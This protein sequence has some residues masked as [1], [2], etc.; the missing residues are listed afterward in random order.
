VPRVR[1]SKSAIFRVADWKLRVR[2]QIEKVRVV[3]WQQSSE[4]R[5]QIGLRRVAI[6]DYAANL[7]HLVDIAKSRD[8]DVVFLLLSNNEDLG[9]QGDAR[10]MKAWTPYR[11]VMRETAER[12][13]APVI[14]VPALFQASGLSKQD[15]FLDKMH[16]TARGHRII[17][18]ALGALLQ[19][20]G[21]H[22][23]KPL[24]RDGTGKSRPTYEDPFLKGQDDS[25]A[26][27]SLGD[28]PPSEYRIEGVVELSDFPQGGVIHL[29]VV[30]PGRNQSEVLKSIQIQGPGSFVLPVGA[31]RQVVI[32]AYVDPEG[33]GP[34]AD[35]ARYA[36]EDDVIDLSDGPAKGVVIDLNG[37]SLRGG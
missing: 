27:G 1:L 29:D 21:W 26:S 36:F 5:G 35:D 19:E 18:E 9:P 24:W 8:A 16:P 33:D 32:R 22:E 20:R 2:P 7:D 10:A 6:N 15:L 25:S 14:D 28:A 11:E 23:G 3:D 17:G 31:A 12:H 4:D 13:G 37:G 30:P 34:D